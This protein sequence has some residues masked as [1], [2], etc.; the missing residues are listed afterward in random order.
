ML[1]WY[2]PLALVICCEP[3]LVI[4]CESVPNTELGYHFACC[5]AL[6]THSEK[7][8]SSPLP[9]VPHPH[10]AAAC[11]SL[12]RRLSH[13]FLPC[14]CLLLL[15]AGDAGAHHKHSEGLE[16]A[17]K[18]QHRAVADQRSGHCRHRTM[19]RVRLAPCT[20]SSAPATRSSRPASCHAQG[21]AVSCDTAQL[22][23]R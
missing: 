21:Y 1:V 7:V 3:S 14:C 11:S 16:H 22:H 8:L 23:W 19:R 6:I 4:C 13:A 2:C 10:F 9:Q 20:L 12:R 15:P 5:A 17:P 18:T